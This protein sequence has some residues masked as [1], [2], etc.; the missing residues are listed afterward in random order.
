M[1]IA[2]FSDD[3]LD[4]SKGIDQLLTKYSEK[5]PEVIFPASVDQDDFSQSIIRKCIENKVKVT[6]C[7]RNAAGLDHLLKQA[8]DIVI[9]DD[10]T[11]EVLRQLSVGDSVGIVWTDSIADHLVLHYVEDLALDIWDITGDLDPIEID[12]PFIGMDSE[13][14][15]DGMH[16]A[17]TVFV[18]MMVA[19]IASTVM[20]SI[21]Q[22]AIEHIMKN[23]DTKNFSPFEDDE[24]D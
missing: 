16:K 19:F 12:D 15:H 21:R 22:A 14:L 13:D 4:V 7:F 20:E 2:I 6:V 8:D 1:K 11:K 10:P 24:E 17:I 18:D 3:N 9:C 5:S 23:P